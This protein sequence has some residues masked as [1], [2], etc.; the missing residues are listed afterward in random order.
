MHALKKEVGKKAA[1][2]IA[3]KII[4]SAARHV[5][6]AVHTVVIHHQHKGQKALAKLRTVGRKVAEQITKEA[7]ANHKPKHVAAHQG[8]QA[9]KAAVKFAS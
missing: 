3:K 9:G 7:L 2:H 8:A 1:H 5:V 6:I 4:K